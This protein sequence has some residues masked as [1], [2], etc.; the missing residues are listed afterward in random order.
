VTGYW[1]ECLLPKRPRGAQ[2]LS[3][4]GGPGHLRV[5]ILTEQV[6]L[7]QA[8]PGAGAGPRGRHG[9]RL[10]RPLKQMRRGELHPSLAEDVGGSGSS[11]V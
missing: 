5:A 8:M 3:C 11:E 6:G 1:R 9:T 4:A 7:G 10:S 2:V